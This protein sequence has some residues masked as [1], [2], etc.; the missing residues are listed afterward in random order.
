[1]S[2][3]KEAASGLPQLSVLLTATA[4]MWNGTA[5]LWTMKQMLKS[6]EP[7]G[8]WQRSCAATRTFS[9]LGYNRGSQPGIN[10]PPGV[11]F[12]YPGGKFNDAEVTIL[13]F[14]QR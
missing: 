12:T 2:S 4:G 5:T 9:Q 6:T 3:E 8:F 1:M 14:L 13:F 10:L 7:A 11:N